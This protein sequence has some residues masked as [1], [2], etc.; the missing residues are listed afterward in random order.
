MNKK[1][2]PRLKELLKQYIEEEKIPGMAVGIVMGE[3]E[4]TFGFGVRNIETQKPVD[5]DTVFHMAS[6]SKTMLSTVMMRLVEAG[7]IDLDAP[8]SRYLPYFRLHDGKEKDITIRRALSHSSGLTYTD[9]SEWGRG[10][11]DDGALERYAKSLT[12]VKRLL[13][14]DQQFYY[15]NTLYDVLGDV[16]AKAT[17]M[18]FEDAIEKYALEPLKM[19][20]SSFFKDG[21]MDGNKASPHVL[22]TT[23]QNMIT[24]SEIYPYNRMHAP[25]S[26]LHSCVS[27]LVKYLRFYTQ[28]DESFL[29]NET[30]DQFLQPVQRVSKE[31]S[32]FIG[33][34]WFLSEYKGQCIH[35]HSG[36]DTG[37]NTKLIIMPDRKAGAV[38]MCNADY[39][40]VE[41]LTTLFLQL[42]SGEELTPVIPS[43][44]DEVFQA[45]RDKDIS[46]LREAFMLCMDKRE[47]ISVIKDI[48]RWLGLLLEEGELQS[49][50]E[51][52]ALTSTQFPG[53]T[54]FLPLEAQLLKLL[55]RDEAAKRTYQ[56]VL[57][58]NPGHYDVFREIDV[59]ENQ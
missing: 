56:K 48:S 45:I 27:D 18:S 30:V 4:F 53:E 26:S 47:E 14:P 58:E 5:Q 57:L 54:V 40:D 32:A 31:P 55:G 11:D 10:P 29:K 46:R 7:K 22:T 38:F 2:I 21:V 50:K 49:A 34:G 39:V 59:E 19:C 33:L 37:F 52:L 8:I 12:H 43:G 13:E 17:G 36:S 41:Q 1:P 6:V 9:D 23:S 42:L 20:R 44:K 25:C 24:L 28:R 15:N 35:Y 51:I 16:I 3:D